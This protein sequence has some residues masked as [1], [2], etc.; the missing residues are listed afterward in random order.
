MSHGSYSLLHIHAWSW[1]NKDEV[2]NTKQIVYPVIDSLKSIRSLHNGDVQVVGELDQPLLVVSL[3][4]AHVVGKAEPEPAVEPLVQVDPV[5]HLDQPVVAEEVPPGREGDP[6]EDQ[7]VVAVLEQPEPVHRQG[8]A[9][10]I[11][12]CVWGGGFTASFKF[13]CRWWRIWLS[14]EWSNWYNLWAKTMYNVHIFIHLIYIL[15]FQKYVHC[16]YFLPK[17]GVKTT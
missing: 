11:Y 8:D 13:Y 12:M 5:L 16:L 3:H 15:I 1:T 2:K 17:K 4:H 10:P 9:D 14:V 6:L 7:Q